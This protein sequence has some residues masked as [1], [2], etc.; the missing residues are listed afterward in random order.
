MQ[1]V[2]TLAQCSFK[3]SASSMQTNILEMCSQPRKLSNNSGRATIC[4]SLVPRGRKFAIPLP[5]QLVYKIAL[6]A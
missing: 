1:E 3:K 5:R 4:R 2:F 6:N